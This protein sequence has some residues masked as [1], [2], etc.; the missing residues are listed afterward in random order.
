[1][2]E[3]V[4][5]AH[6][7]DE[8]ATG[9]METMAKPASMEIQRLESPADRPIISIEIHVTAMRTFPTRP[10]NES[11]GLRR[12]AFNCSEVTENP[13]LKR[14]AASMI[15]LVVTVPCVPGREPQSIFFSQRPGDGIRPASA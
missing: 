11:E 12:S 4:C 2:L 5:W 8:V 7:V 14:S 6:A 15:K 13:A 9:I 10:A 3:F 1:M